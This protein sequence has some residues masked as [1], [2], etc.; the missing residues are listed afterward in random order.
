[1]QELYNKYYF[2]NIEKLKK[3]KINEKKNYVNG[4]EDLILLKYQ[5]FLYY[6]RQLG[7]VGC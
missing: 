6:Q 4:L 3:A 1:M 2:E 7:R 5:L